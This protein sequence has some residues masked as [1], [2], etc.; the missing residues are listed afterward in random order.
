[1]KRIFS[2]W[3]LIYNLCFVSAFASNILNSGPT[4]RQGKKS[5]QAHP[6]IHP[7]K[8][9]NSLQGNEA[10]LYEFIVRHFLACCSKDAQGLETKVDIKIGDEQVFPSEFA[11]IALSIIFL[12]LLVVV[13]TLKL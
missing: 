12:L 5:D 1:M 13:V 11:V 10:K 3:S 9:A 4:P 7:T 6:P 8:Y 2:N